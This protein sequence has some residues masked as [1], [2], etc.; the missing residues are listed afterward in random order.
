RDRTMEE[1]NDVL[2]ARLKPGGAIVMVTTRWHE[3]DPAGQLLPEAYDGRSGWVDC[4]DGERWFVV[5]LPAESE[6]ADDPLGRQ[7]GELLWPEWFTAEHFAPHKLIPRTWA[8]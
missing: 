3:L 4:R 1:F 5:N 2:R 7:P 8:S 6:H